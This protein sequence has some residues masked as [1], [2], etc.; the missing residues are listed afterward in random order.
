VLQFGFS[1]IPHTF[2]TVPVQDTYTVRLTLAGQPLAV[3]GDVD[4]IVGSLRPYGVITGKW[5]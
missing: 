1:L 5:I 2:E 4:R 3:V